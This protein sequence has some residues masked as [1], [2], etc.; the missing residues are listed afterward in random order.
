MRAGFF[1]PVSVGG[2][3]CIVRFLLE[4]DLKKIWNGEEITL[5]HREI[6]STTIYAVRCIL[7]QM[8]LRYKLVNSKASLFHYSYANCTSYAGASGGNTLIK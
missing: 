5:I 1:K 4:K 8:M 3:I 6:N 2:S 7:W